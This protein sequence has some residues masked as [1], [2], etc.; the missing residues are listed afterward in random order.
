VVFRVHDGG[1]GG[2]VVALKVLRPDV[3]QDD[4]AALARLAREV[5]TA[6]ELAHP[7]LV[8]VFD[9][10]EAEGIHFLTMEY[11]EGARCAS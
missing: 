10:D 2:E 7:N 5:A 3:A 11:V 8:R 9:L 6:R 4:P 1:R